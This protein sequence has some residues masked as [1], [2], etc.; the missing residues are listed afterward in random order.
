MCVLLSAPRTFNVYV[1]KF[2]I[3]TSASLKDVLTEMGMA[4]MFGDRADLTGISEGGRLSVSEVRGRS[5]HT[6]FLLAPQLP[7]TAFGSAGCSSS[8]PGCGRGRSHR[9]RCYR[10][11]N[12][13][14]LFSSRPRAE[15][16]PSIHG[17]YHRAQH[18]EH[19]LPGQDYQPQDLMD[20]VLF[21]TI[22]LASQIEFLIKEINSWHVELF[23]H[24]CF[25][26]LVR[27]Q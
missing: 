5:V 25:L 3:K 9:R 10:H 4:D 2:S 23:S 7:L 14:L 12:N 6:S 18:R 11:R 15:V 17:Y 27:I 13:T 21:Y 19:P 20:P 16:R 26:Y 1:P 24:V 8:Y 22:R